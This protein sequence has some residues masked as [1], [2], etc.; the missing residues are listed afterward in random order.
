MACVQKYSPMRAILTL[1]LA[2]LFVTTSVFA[3]ILRSPE[4]LIEAFFNAWRLNNTT[5]ISVLSGN[6]QKG[7]SSFGNTITRAKV[8]DYSIETQEQIG[9]YR[10]LKTRIKLKSTDYGLRKFTLYFFLKK[11]DGSWVWEEGI[12]FSKLG[13]EPT[14]KRA[15][16]L[17][18]FLRR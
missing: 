6:P 11:V 10:I 17:Y 18:L 9:S 12:D 13:Y 15:L 16:A 5:Y 7:L 4:D 3:G 2:G 14:P 1:M 8:L